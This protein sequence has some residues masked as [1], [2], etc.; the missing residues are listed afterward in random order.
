MPD[1]ASYFIGFALVR[2]MSK[3]SVKRFKRLFRCGGLNESVRL[4]FKMSSSS[5]DNL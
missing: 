2:E 4:N 1:F 3:I 5:S